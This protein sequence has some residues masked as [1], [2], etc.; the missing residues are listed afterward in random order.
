MK[1]ILQESFIYVFFLPIPINISIFSTF[2]KN[3]GSYFCVFE[4]QSYL[5]IL[6]INSYEIISLNSIVFFDSLWIFNFSCFILFYF[7]YCFYGLAFTSK[8][9]L[10]TCTKATCIL[11]QLGS[12][13]TLRQ[14]IHLIYSVSLICSTDLSSMLEI[15]DTTDLLDSPHCTLMVL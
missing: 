2:L 5:I 15:Q 7:I 1:L 9:I 6:I 14:L 3:Y 13:T 11:P 12:L 8:T 10:L 4:I